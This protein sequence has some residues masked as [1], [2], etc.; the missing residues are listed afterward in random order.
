MLALSPP[1]VDSMRAVTII[2][3]ILLF[4]PLS[5]AGTAVWLG[6]GRLPVNP[7]LNPLNESIEGWILPS[8]ETITSSAFSVEPLFAPAADNG[9]HWSVDTN[10]GFSTG[11]HN[12]TI[13]QR[14]YGLTLA[15]IDTIDQFSEF[16]S[17]RETFIDLWPRGNNSSIWKPVNL[18]DNNGQWL[19]DLA[20]SGNIV[21][22]TSLGTNLSGENEA[23]LQTKTWLL[24]SLA[25]NLTFSFQ[26]W[27]SLGQSDAAWIELSLDGG[28]SWNVLEIDNYDGY[29]ALSGTNAW[30]GNHSQ[31]EL[32]SLI[33]DDI[34]Q[35]NS[36]F[37]LTI[38][39]QIHTESNCSGWF[40]DDI[41]L[42][43]EGDQKGAWFHGN[44]NGQ[45]DADAHGRLVMP[46]DLSSYTGPLQLKYQTDWD[47]AG[48]YHDNLNVYFSL[49]NA[50][51][52]TLIS[53]PLGIP[54]SGIGYNGKI[55]G[56]Q[57]FGWREIIHD[58][59]VGTSTHINASNALFSFEVTTDS[60]INF[61]G[62]ST[63]GWEGVMV[64]SLMIISGA[65]SPTVSQHLVYNFTTN[66]E[67]SIVNV[68]N[69]SNQW[70]YVTNYG[71]NPPLI[72]KDS[73]EETRFIEEGWFVH[74]EYG[75][76][77]WEQGPVNSIGGFGPISWPTQ[78][79]GIA[80]DLDG[81]YEA[82]TWSHLISP[83]FEIPSNSSSRFR[84]DHWV[85]TEAAFDGGA[86]FI[87]E[88]GGVS[89]Q[90]FG[91]NQSGFYDQVTYVSSFS[92]FY[93]HGIFD[94]SSNPSACSSKTKP[95]NTSTVE[96]DY[97]SGKEVMFRYSFYSDPYVEGDGWYIDMT[98]VQTDIHELSGN[99]TSPIIDVDEMGWGTLSALAYTPQ[100]T[101]INV[102]VL[103][104]D[105]TELEGWSN[106]S[107]PLDIEISALEHPR[108]IFRLNL[109]ST[110]ELVTPLVERLHLG[111]NLYLSP[112]DVDSLGGNVER[113]IFY[114]DGQ[115]PIV[116]TKNTT[117]WRAFNTV[118]ITCNGD[119]L[120]IEILDEAM[121]IRMV[122]DPTPP[123]SFVN[124]GNCP[125]S[126]VSLS[127]ITNRLSVQITI[128]PGGWFQS[129]ALEPQTLLP[130]NNVSITLGDNDVPVYSWQGAMGQR[131][132]IDKVII[133][134]VDLGITNLVAFNQ[135]V[136]SYAQISLSV[137]D[138]EPIENITHD[139]DGSYSGGIVFDSG[140]GI[141]FLSVDSAI[142][143]NYN[144]TISGI[145]HK[146]KRFTW[147]ITS[148][149]P[150][151]L[152]LSKANV[153]W[154]CSHHF[155]I[156]ESVISASLTDNGNGR[157]SLDTHLSADRGGLSLN[158]TIEHLPAITD[159]WLDI[160]DSTIYPKQIFTAISRHQILE[161]STPLS[162]IRLHLSP[163]GSEDDSVAIFDIDRLTTGGR[164]KQITG[165]SQA[166]IDHGNSSL[167]IEGNMI[168]V[169]WSI[170]AQWHFD[171]IYRLYWLVS[172]WDDNGLRLG[173]ASSSSG[174]GQ[175]SAVEN[176]LEVIHFT[177]NSATESLHER[178]SSSWPNEIAYN[179]SIAISGKV[180]LSGSSENWIGGD[181]VELSIEIS[182]ENSS[183]ILD[184]WLVEVSEDG[185]FS[186]VIQTPDI[187]IIS[188]G[189]R[190][191][192]TPRILEYGPRSMANGEQVDDTDVFQ[193]VII[194]HDEDP[195]SAVELF[196]VAP[197]GNQI[198]DG[199]IWHP[200]ADIP[201]RL[202]IEENLRLSEVIQMWVDVG[203]GNYLSRVV[204]VQSE[205]T[206][207]VLDLPL[208]DEDT[209]ILDS[210]SKGEVRVYFTG[211]DHS[212]IQLIDGGSAEEPMATV[213]Y[214]PRFQTSIPAETLNLDAINGVLYPG[215]SHTFSFDLIDANGIESIDRIRLDLIDNNNANSCRIEWIIWSNEV[216]YD[217]T[218][219]ID[220]PSANAVKKQLLQRWTISIT[221]ELSWL[222]DNFNGMAKTPSLQII[223]EN[224][225]LGLGYE[226]LT[227][228]NWTISSGISLQ[229][230]DVI[231]T[232]EPFGM[233]VNDTSYLSATDIIEIEIMAFH[234]DTNI[235]A[236]YLPDRLVEIKLSG[237]LQTF[238][239]FANLDENGTIIVTANLSEV[240][241]PNPQ[242][243]I[244]ATLITLLQ[245]RELSSDSIDLIFDT[246][247]P[248]L[249]YSEN[250]TLI[251]S[252]SLDELFVFVVLKDEQGLDGDQ[253]IL[254]WLYARDGV[255]LTETESSV[256]IYSNEC[257]L[258]ECE[259]S[260]VVDIN[261][262]RG[263]ELTKSDQILFWF[264]GGDASGRPIKGMGSNYSNPILPRIT[265]IAYEPVLLD[266]ETTPYRPY[267]GQIITIEIELMNRGILDG[268][269]NISIIDGDGKV[270]FEENHD[271]LS[272]VPII[273]SIEIE[274]WKPGRLGL[275]LVIDDNDPIPLP[276][277]DVSSEMEDVSSQ[278]GKMIGLG[279]LSVISAGLILFVAVI[280]KRQN[281]INWYEEE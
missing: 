164:F 75:V 23:Y 175:Y 43:N 28:L 118:D 116:M 275:S 70:Q 155:T 264:S 172:A 163:S 92:P 148:G 278:E 85:C 4:S 248:T 187:G 71:D 133:D 170:I 134:D 13:S 27:L 18:N 2:V 265:W 280:R 44:L 205:S 93:N 34:P 78:D 103:A 158:G 257:D 206:S 35:L 61:G 217:E 40:L 188:S 190:L 16:N 227:P 108:L 76:A 272:N 119:N 107:L 243:R 151:D 235:L 90:H 281:R 146:M 50:S 244:S 142:G 167:T 274:A 54:G 262:S 220:K 1:L 49:D 193:Q 47:L 31:W 256:I 79:S 168:V 269:S 224:N 203:D 276:L 145:N 176:D 236:K 184:Q 7:S 277:A 263:D 59:P 52:W 112:S 159:E 173:P 39:F 101:S 234:R 98:G 208:V 64:D 171:D 160:P 102:D 245:E 239:I 74:H 126:T 178:S 154:R 83:S 67:Q 156:S 174:G 32:Q 242:A 259:Y 26:S 86:V 6:P 84:L 223:D 100:G 238:E 125:K 191:V 241:F 136:E 273:I 215:E 258:F 87:S 72:D 121:T 19:P 181:E 128:Q 20:I 110:N 182:E 255:V 91:D 11:A 69:M 247:S 96:L 143:E 229:I 10:P 51:T 202:V 127:D 8:N 99:W 197:G 48:S 63:D 152:S 95:F 254:H 38:R 109:I 232:S 55:Y 68:T 88:D 260:A 25:K 33:L 252:D 9:S 15:T 114:N 77:P 117:L 271:F 165:S 94:G 185:S 60:I 5:S 56:Q 36:S 266:I 41:T 111:S 237:G 222:N 135:S 250:L 73:L 169:N 80:M 132:F 212:G 149:S 141:Q 213:Y 162:N 37:S 240:I 161:G 261:S 200:G 210:S 124:T 147:N 253:L 17:G 268:A 233:I 183:N 198:A 122:G 140:N 189:T 194:V 157:S 207:Q 66:D 130:P 231:D 24:P 89:W 139:W 62:P 219:F 270:L 246:S 209:I 230:N 45:Y 138:D 166:I 221:F 82:N 30:S 105:G 195:P 177:A 53:G 226:D 216:V 42:S 12:G 267:L 180:R 137:I 225:A 211:L 123:L 14:D 65:N 120:S 104:A 153:I 179:S 196:V 97:Y 21:A 218:C 46:I 279:I 113:K 204:N 192:I 249:H 81:D 115:S 201:L 150:F 57:S 3:L 251:R 186:S 144:D 29:S 214:H 58:L 106:R 129:L 131:N 228:L 199:H 22:G